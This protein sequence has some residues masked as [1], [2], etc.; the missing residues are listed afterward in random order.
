[1]AEVAGFVISGVQLTSL[2]QTCLSFYDQIESLRNKNSDMKY[3]ATRASVERYKLSQLWDRLNDTPMHAG[4]RKLVTDILESTKIT[5]GRLSKNLNY[6]Q[7]SFDLEGGQ[8][9]K[10]GNNLSRALRWLASDKQTIEQMVSRFKELNADLEALLSAPQRASLEFG[11]V[12]HSVASTDIEELEWVHS[13]YREEL[14]AISTAAK[15]KALQIGHFEGIQTGGVPRS[16]IVDLEAFKWAPFP[17]ASGDVQYDA[18]L[19]DVVGKERALAL[20]ASP[21]GISGEEIPVLVEWRNGFK[22]TSSI[23]GRRYRLDQLVCAL[24][25]M[26]F[27]PPMTTCYEAS[28]RGTISFGVLECLGWLMIDFDYSRIGLVFRLPNK[29]THRPIS[30]YDMIRRDRRAKNSGPALG[31]RFSMAARL[32]KRVANMIVVGWLHKSMRSHN[33]L[34]FKQSEVEPRCSSAMVS[35]DAEDTKSQQRLQEI[36]ELYLTGFSYA[37]PGDLDSA[38]LSTLPTYDP[39]FALYRPP[40]SMQQRCSLD[41]RDNAVSA[42]DK[43]LL[44]PH[45]DATFDIYGLG[46]ILLEIG[47]WKTIG[48]VYEDCRKGSHRRSNGRSRDG[49]SISVGVIASGTSLQPPASGLLLKEFQESPMMLRLVVDSLGPRTGTIYRDVVRKC[50]G[51]DGWQ[52]PTRSRDVKKAH[53]PML[54]GSNNEAEFLESILAS[55]SECKA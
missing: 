55:L 21:D 40:R 13:A 4:Q 51:F 23:E 8:A 17:T 46:I 32:V 3:L 6:H 20:H 28:P 42:D 30:L 27:S 52:A 43:Q 34:M 39:A 33:V 35:H 41:A 5:V 25:Q 15:V 7:G 24:S 22:S 19:M 50:L 16:Q 54:Q 9:V 14:P 48:E 1:M 26:S 45:L 11:L 38:D 44:T 29:Q 47:M 18:S 2:F 53:E 49:T 37:R 10:G 12:A 31:T 36:E